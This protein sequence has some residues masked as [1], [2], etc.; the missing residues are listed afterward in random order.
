M[1]SLNVDL[2]EGGTERVA[3]RVTPRNPG[4]VRRFTWLA[5][6]GWILALALA[7]SAAL[8]AGTVV[9]IPAAFRA[10]NATPKAARLEPSRGTGNELV[11]HHYC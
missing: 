3:N 6:V 9:G 10:L 4:P 1:G 11:W 5:S 8:L 7:V 2:A